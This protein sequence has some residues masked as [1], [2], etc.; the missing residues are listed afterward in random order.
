[1]SPA[2]NSLF[3]HTENSRAGA[4]VHIGGG[5]KFKCSSDSGAVLVTEAAIIQKQYDD[6]APF[7]T[8]IRDNFKN[9]HRRHREL[10]NSPSPFECWIV[11]MT[12]S[13]PQCSIACWQGVKQDIAIHFSVKTSADVGAASIS[14]SKRVSKMTGGCWRHYGTGKSTDKGKVSSHS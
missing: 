14:S 1:M 7:K 6:M 4:S 10:F 11:T 13:T 9:L 3:V 5:F 8:W 12:Y 2:Y